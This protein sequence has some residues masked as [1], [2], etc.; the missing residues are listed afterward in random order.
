[1]TDEEMIAAHIRDK[2]VTRVKTVWLV[3]SPQS[4]A[5][6]SSAP[7]VRE[8]RK[9]PN[10]PESVRRGILEAYT[11][12]PGTIREVAAEFGVSEETAN[13]VLKSAGVKS[14]PGSLRRRRPKRDD[15]RR[16][17]TQDEIAAVAYHAS[18]QPITIREVASRYGIS[19]DVM[20][21]IL[22]RVGATKL[23]RGQAGSLGRKAN[24]IVPD[25]DDA[26]FLKGSLDGSHGGRLAVGAPFFDP[27]DCRGA[28]LSA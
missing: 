7:I 22:I 10:I 27:D 5:A 13:A 25:E 24:A 23:T 14:K 3:A 20:R 4:A 11:S 6:P 15:D 16:P 9:E 28:Y 18:N 1:M 21:N 19:Y 17:L 26:R 8:V 12:K 2:G